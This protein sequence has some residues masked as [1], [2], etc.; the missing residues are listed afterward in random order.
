MTTSELLSPLTGTALW[1]GDPD[2]RRRAPGLEPL[3]PPG[4]RRRGPRR[5]RDRRAER[6][7][8]RRTPRPRRRGD[9]DR[10]R[11]HH[12]VRRR[13]ARQHLADARGTRRPSDPSGHGPGRALD[14]PT[15]FRSADAY[16]LAG[17]PGSSPHV[18][19]VGYTLGGG[20]G[21]LGR[22]FGLSCAPRDP[23]PGRHRRRRDHRRERHRERRPVLGDAGRDRELRDRHGARA[24]SRRPRRGLRRQPLLPA[25]AGRRRPRDVRPM[26]AHRRRTS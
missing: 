12:A 3:G 2:V 15:S 18:G 10:P 20:F 23:G 4:T 5:E 6:G 19:I 13:G 26:G 14:G 16:G 17:L 21:W 1:P 7:P 24:R 22:A 8:V 25:R 11:R 9:V